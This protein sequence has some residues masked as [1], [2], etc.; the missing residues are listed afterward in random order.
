MRMKQRWWA[1]ALAVAVVLLLVLAGLPYYLGIKAEASL[2]Q[3]QTLL[4]QTSFLAVER[5]EYQRGWFSSTETLVLR[6]KPSFLAN[7]QRQLP[8]NLQTVLREPITLVSEVRHGPF[9]GSLTPVRAQVRTELRFTPETEKIL[10]RFF[11]Q[12]A[13][14]T[15]HNTLYLT[16]G[17]Q[18]QLSIPSFDY[19]E[20]SGI[21][22][23]WQGLESRMDYQPGFVE[24][25]THTVSPGLRMVLADKGEASYSGLDIRTHSRDGANQ[26]TLG[27]SQLQLQ[28]FTLQWHQGAEYDI[29]L[30]EL[31]NLVTDLQIGAFINPS[32][33]IMPAKVSLDQLTFSTEL[34]EDGEWI[35][36]RGQFGFAKLNYGD[37]AYGP[38]AI[39]A[40]AEHLQAASLLALK[41]K[42]T[43]LST[44]PLDAEQMQQA[45]VA[46]ARNEGLGL[47]SN[48]PVIRLQ[49]FDLQMPEGMVAVSGE[50]GFK[51]LNAEDMRQ[52]N[53]LLRKTEADIHLKLPQKLLEEMAVSQARN[54]FTVD[55]S[56]GGEEALLDID[57]TV[58]LMVSSTI[59]SMQQDGYLKV[60]DGML[61]TDITIRDSQLQL[62]GKPF[63]TEPEPEPWEAEAASAPAA[64]A[65]SQ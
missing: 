23:A 36:S 31:V 3:Q 55:D 57:N 24:Y 51:G 43:E 49:R 42:L 17:G 11:G 14:A 47:F 2:K 45:V 9:A 19:E 7:V 20:L 30:N 53:T 27:N 38:L 34:N 52:I 41:H 18:L 8:D 37:T 5:H 4:A 22:M 62:N 39:E 61:E 44:R 63:V 60:T 50:I 10:M 54:I 56:A 48:N 26:I 6:F 28:N 29:K 21:K 35:N 13:P 64:Q 59:R 12:Q 25:D 46:A 65:A 16:G 40:S 32:G 15:L 58:R 1:A 33:S